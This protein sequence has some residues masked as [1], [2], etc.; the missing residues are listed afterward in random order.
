MKKLLISGCS[1]SLVYSE[2]KNDL[3]DLFDVDEVVNLSQEGSSPMRQIRAVIE[4]IAQN[5]K[6]HMV[7]MP[8]SHYDRFDLPIA[9]DFDPLHNK[10]HRC[11]WSH[12]LSPG[13][14]DVDKDALEKYFK[15]GVMVN[16]VQHTIHDD[17][18]VRLLTF[19]SYLQMNKIKH[20]IFDTGNYYEKFWIPYLSIDEENNSGYQPGMKKRD[21][22]DN[23]PGIYKFTSFCSNVWQYESLTEEQKKDYREDERPLPYPCDDNTK[24]TTH[25]GKDEAVKLMQYLKKEGA[26][27]G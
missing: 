2:I 22:I 6:P 10:H 15:S 8:V 26:V 12:I 27:Y 23:C 21:L 13:E 1:Y 19:Q 20:L 24:A 5:G 25:Y 14:V 7:M 17:L 16:K 11:S 9:M 3:I 4:W 18:F